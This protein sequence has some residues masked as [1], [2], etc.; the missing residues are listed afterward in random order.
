[1]AGASRTTGR[2][3]PAIFACMLAEPP[4]GQDLG[5]PRPRVAG[6]LLLSLGLAGLAGCTEAAPDVPP[7]PLAAAAPAH[8]AGTVLTVDGEPLLAGEVEELA[9]AVERLH[10]EYSRL[11]A[12]R[13]ALTGE[14]LPRLAGRGLAP[15]AWR[16]AR[17]ACA[18]FDP[19][20]A[21]PSAV[22]RTRRGNFAELGLGP[23]SAACALELDTWSEPLEFFGRFLRLR[24][25]ARTP[26]DDPRREEL[27]LEEVEFA[28]L[29]G[30]RARELLQEALDRAALVIVDPA[31]RE[32]VPEAWQHRMRPDHP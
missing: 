25:T 20:A 5:P 21:A 27:E 16:A 30:A 1:M 12:R 32:C 15:E 3:T 4:P 11:H 10:P 17:E 18:A 8:P 2:R 31:W 26:A 7:A 14:L 23:W 22:R 24:V 6:R 28:Y 29:D 13:L 19:A 9:A